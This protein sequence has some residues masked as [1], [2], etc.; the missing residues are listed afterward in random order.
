MAQYIFRFNSVLL[1]CNS[2][3]KYNIKYFYYHGL[4]VEKRERKNKTDHNI[5]IHFILPIYI[6]LKNINIQGNFFF[7]FGR[8]KRDGTLYIFFYKLNIKLRKKKILNG[9]RILTD[10]EQHKHEEFKKTRIT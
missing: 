5:F 2:R 9:K 4:K 6:K 10:K 8:K 1:V 3:N 7:N